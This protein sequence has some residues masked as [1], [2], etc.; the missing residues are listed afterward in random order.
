MFRSWT[1]PEDEEDDVGAL[2]KKKIAGKEPGLSC[3]R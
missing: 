1:M 2:I 3:G